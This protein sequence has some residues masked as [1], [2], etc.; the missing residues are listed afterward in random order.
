MY[1]QQYDVA[2]IRRQGRNLSVNRCQKQ[3]SRGVSRQRCSENMLQIYRRTPMTKFDFNKVAKQLLLR[4]SGYML[5]HALLPFLFLMPVFIYKI[6]GN[7]IFFFVL[8][9]CVTDLTYQNVMLLNF[10]CFRRHVFS[11]NTT[12]L[13]MRNYAIK[14]RC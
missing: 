7:L 1:G 11:V 13:L 6:F 3:P 9:L 2:F 14:F 10:G 8:V 4:S 12:F 5:P